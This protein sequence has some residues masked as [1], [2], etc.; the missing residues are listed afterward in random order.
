MI[1]IY[2][3]RNGLVF[4]GEIANSVEE[5]KNYLANKYGITEK[6][7]VGHNN[8]GEPI[9]DLKFVPLYNKSAFVFKE[10]TIV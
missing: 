10:V 4:T 6:I 9:Y 1:G 2:Q 7:L 8:K 3:Y 5:A